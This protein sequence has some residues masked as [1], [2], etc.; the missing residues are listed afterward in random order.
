LINSDM[1]EWTIIDLYKWSMTLVNVRPVIAEESEQA[2]NVRSC[3][4]LPPF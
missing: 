1:P 3:S 2:G 4:A